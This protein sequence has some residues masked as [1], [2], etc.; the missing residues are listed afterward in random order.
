MSSPRSGMNNNDFLTPEWILGAVITFAL[1]GAIGW[2]S[3]RTEN[4]RQEK[5]QTYGP[6]WL[7]YDD[8]CIG[9]N[10]ELRGM[11]R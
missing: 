5:C 3:G 1:I 7:V 2:Y 4:Y 6:D 11:P 10:G 9:P 8:D